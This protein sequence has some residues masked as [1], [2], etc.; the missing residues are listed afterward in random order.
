[1]K[2]KHGNLLACAI[3]LAL[4]APGW[5]LAQAS[6]ESA[7]E[8][9][10]ASALEEVVVTA[11]KREETIF[12]VP[13]SIEAF[14]QE[15]LDQ[16]GIRNIED[17]ARYTP[18]MN[19]SQGFSNI[20]YISIRGLSSS[21]GATMTGIYID[22]TPIH[23]RSLVL[24]TFFYPALYDL[25]RVEV[26]RGPQGTLFGSSAMG[27]AVRFITAK[28]NLDEFEGNA[29][30]ELG[31]TEDGDPSYEGGAAIGGPIVDGKIGFRINA[32]YRK[33]GGYIDRVPW[34]PERGTTEANSNSTE[35]F[36]A[37][38]ALTF[39]PIENLT[40]TPSIFHQEVTRNDVSTYW[41]FGNGS[42]RPQPPI[43]QAG[44]GIASTGSDKTD[45]FQ[46]KANWDVGKVSLVSNTSYV[47]RHITS[48]DDSTAF[49][50]DLYQGVFGTGALG[51][52]F[53]GLILP[54]AGGSGPLNF[55]LSMPGLPGSP[56]GR[57][58]E[59]TYINL[60]MIQEGWTQEFRVQ[61]NDADARLQW[62]TGAF[63]QHTEQKSHEWDIA[64]WATD[65][66]FLGTGSPIAQAIF[67]TI[68]LP[69]GPTGYVA[70]SLSEIVDDQYAVF[71]QADYHLTDKWTLTAGARYSV[72]EFESE[73]TNV[74]VATGTVIASPVRTSK[75]EPFTPKLGVQYQTDKDI[76][77]YASAAEGFR[78]G[79]VN[80]ASEAPLDD[81]CEAGLALIGYTEIPAT[82]ESDSTWNYEV[83]AKGN[84]GNWAFAAD[85]FYTEW[86]DVQRTRQIPGCIGIFTDN[87]GKAV[88]QGAE[89]NVTVTPADGLTLNA[90]V[91]YVDAR[92]AET[93]YVPGTENT[94]IRDGDRFATPWTVNLT[95]DYETPINW[96]DARAYGTVQYTW[97]SEWD[98]KPGNVA[99]NPVLF[100]TD[101][102]NQLN[103]RLGIRR[104]GFDVSAFV[105]NVSNS[106]D[107]IGRLHFQPSERIQIQTWRPRTYGV[108]VRYNF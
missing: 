77:W 83:G 101:D 102:Q 12:D 56:G 96:E 53:N 91:A 38:A 108:T 50:L 49:I 66:G 33:D 63:F 3:A 104:A 9:S 82:Y 29:R 6:G 72:L 46:L 10:M 47:D 34:L 103:I 23:I 26:L 55:E 73:A 90:A 19:L 52:L 85:V 45:L 22:D 93:L 42:T 1:M 28:P 39:R 51:G 74:D 84:V 69:V 106:R 64:P 57:C 4:A 79:G 78:S 35:T 40:I 71:G 31:F 75:E 15:L 61:S 89:A 36:V 2:F 87:L 5:A 25:E 105:N 54:L 58:G 16:K 98:A 14:S 107:V 76:M 100:N 68:L 88:S 11:R 13:I 62:V 24:M 94:I 65:G 30:A 95:G 70:D 92:Q 32:N 80:T 21:V 48:T 81:A 8:S 17:L 37:N 41:T 97:R 99:A 43:F 60:D 86:D 67:G 20:K 27:G 44:E 18:G 59:C 7:D